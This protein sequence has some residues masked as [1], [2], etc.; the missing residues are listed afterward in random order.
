M[1]ATNPEE[2]GKF[3][4][5]IIP[6]EDASLLLLAH[7]WAGL[8]TQ[9]HSGK[10]FPSPCAPTSFQGSQSAVSWE[11]EFLAF[12]QGWSRALCQCPCPMVRRSSARLQLQQF[13]FLSCRSPSVKCQS[14]ASSAASGALTGKFGAKSI[15]QRKQRECAF[16][17]PILSLNVLF[18]QGWLESRAGQGRTAACSW[19]TPMRRWRS[20]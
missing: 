17:P 15:C 8:A 14:S 1:V 9:N 6:G 20:G 16:S 11:N 13:L 12:T 3:I 18:S 19:P 4:F 5:E 7:F 10:S 2:G